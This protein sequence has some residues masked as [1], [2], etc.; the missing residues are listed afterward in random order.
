MS[1]S[2]GRVLRG[3]DF[4]KTI[5]FP[6]IFSS[7]VLLGSLFQSQQAQAFP[8]MVR[9]GYVNCTACHVSPTGG[10]MLT[11]Y[12]REL[13]KELMSTWSKE[14][15]QGLL[16]GAVKPP[17]WLHVGGDY[18][19]VYYYQDSPTVRQGRYIFMQA[20]VEVGVD[21]SPQWMGAATIGVQDAD[22]PPGLTTFGERSTVL[23]RRHYL[24]YKPR[25]DLSFRA[26]RFFPAFGVNV[27]DH[28]ISTRKGLGWDEGTESYN[29]EGAWITENWNVYVTGIFGRID[30]SNMNRD[31]GV[32]SSVSYAFGEFNKV[33]VS[34][35]RASDRTTDRWV[36]GPSWIFG[37]AKNFYWIGESDFQFKHAA[38]NAPTT[39]G[40]FVYQKVGYEWVKGLHTF[41][42]H[43]SSR[44]DFTSELSSSTTLG[45]GGQWFIR[46]HIELVAE[47]Q[48]LKAPAL[49]P[50]NWIDVG[51]LLFHYYL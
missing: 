36:M 35:Y 50:N 18:R 8:E 27:P 12:G 21:F 38:A 25:E 2:T 24:M 39:S 7:I 37:F 9:H 4:F 3:G 40:V 10:G 51:T 33:G 45:L 43:E 13:S 41:F 49:F 6:A 19:S 5:S 23:S 34:L 46:P 44:P 32:S 1:K 28:V 47:W 26:G 20:D 30:L 16:Y 17:E 29:L 15:E 11:D 48:K 42:T 31:Q 22:N 14:G